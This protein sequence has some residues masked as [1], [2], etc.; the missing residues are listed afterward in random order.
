[1]L[2]AQKLH[3]RYSSQGRRLRM[4][5]MGLGILFLVLGV[6]S[7]PQQGFLLGM[8]PFL[9]L[10]SFFLS[11]PLFTRRAV[12]KMYAQKPDRDMVVTYQITPDRLET[13]S[14]VASSDAVWRTI[15]RAYRV[16]EGFLLY[17][18]DRML[19]WLPAHG[20]QDPA[21]MERLSELIKTKVDRYDHAG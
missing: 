15:I 8:L 14:E 9:L 18:T 21:D 1:M 3:A 5:F 7:L 13:R 20:F 2:L 4:I 17:P 11:I 6:A 10:A 16:P 19:H 12:Q